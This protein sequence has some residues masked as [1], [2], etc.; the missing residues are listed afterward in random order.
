MRRD[1]RREDKNYDDEKGDEDGGQD[2][3]QAAGVEGRRRSDVI[4][5]LIWASADLRYPR[6]ILE[7]D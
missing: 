5:S 4:A 1:F 7:F 6:T 3:G 2:Q